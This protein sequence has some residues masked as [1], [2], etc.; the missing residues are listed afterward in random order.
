ML[1]VE[2]NN[3]KSKA[4]IAGRVIFWICIALIGAALYTGLTHPVFRIYGSVMSP[5]LSEG[6]IVVAA[7]DTDPRRGDVVA[8]TYNSKI[9]IRRVIAVAGDTVDMDDNGNVFVNEERVDEPYASGKGE[10]GRNQASL[11][12]MP[13]TVPDGAVFVLS[14]SRGAG[15]DSRDKD[16]G[17]L[18]CSSIQGKMMLRIWPL[19]RIGLVR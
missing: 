19:S 9:L 1:K 15:S 18:S 2:K 7:E 14:D 16:I 10:K 11:T 8:V 3:N 12:A 6:D 5:T 17:C 4:S 13:V